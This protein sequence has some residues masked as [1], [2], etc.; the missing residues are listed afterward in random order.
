MKLLRSRCGGPTE[1]CES[2]KLIPAIQLMA[3]AGLLWGMSAQN[4]FSQAQATVVWTGGT[5]ASTG[6]RVYSGLA[7]GEYSRSVD[8][9]NQSQMVISNLTA[10][11]PYFFVVASYDGKGVESPFSNEIRYVPTTNA[12][13]GIAISSPLDGSTFLAPTNLNVSAAVS[14]NG[15]VIT[16]V[17]FLSGSSV[18]GESL[19]APYSFNWTGVAAGDY[20][21]TAQLV[22][23]GG[24]IARS[25]AI[26]I[27]VNSS[28]VGRPS[29]LTFAASSG[30]IS[31]PFVSSAGTISQK[32]QT[33]VT[34]G[35]R[36]LYLF[37]VPTNGNY[38]VSGVVS[39]SSE[40][41]NSFYV[42]IDGE[43]TDPSM[44]WRIPA[45]SGFENRNVSWVGEG[46]LTGK[47][48]PL[49]AGSHQLLVVG[50]DAGVQL[51]SVSI[52]PAGVLPL[53]WRST[54]LGTTAVPGLAGSESNLF[55][56]SGAG[57]INGS[58]DSGR[59][60]YQ[61][62]TGDGEIKAQILLAQ[63]ISPFG[64]TGVMIRDNL[65]VGSRYAFMGVDTSGNYAF[66]RRT[67]PSTSPATVLSGY[68]SSS[69]LWVR[70]TRSGG[71]L[72]G[73]K[74]NDGTT[75]S[76]IS[77]RKIS[78]GSTVY[79]GLL[80]SSGNASTCATA[81]FNSVTANP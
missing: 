57:S 73:Y 38:I 76:L 4:G 26:N 80:D 46:S 14:A 28:A 20:V 41:A 10:G 51:A 58:A 21:L 18:V 17:Q 8:A 30:V 27:S 39:A 65:G 78:M 36:A 60:V 19:S 23:D 1:S 25:P 6:Y 74:S 3:L 68:G 15:H 79:F 11:T 63:S 50:R 56:L 53:P 40:G 70:L 35:G 66:Q 75:W 45:T 67:S 52:L 69:A 54:D 9:G 49:A 44:I 16:K 12:N 55:N 47:I 5:N 48:F 43:P 22:Y 64:R 42:N 72:S 34:N 59:F 29:T 33:G 31:S 61:T 7:S 71:T 37:D 81:I 2:R 32:V 13:P 77:S 62:L 24:Q